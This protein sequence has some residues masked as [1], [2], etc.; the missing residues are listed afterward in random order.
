MVWRASVYAKVTK[1][2]ITV[3]AFAV[4][5]LAV[6]SCLA[7]AVDAASP[8]RLYAAGF[9][10]SYL[11]P[12][13][14]SNVSTGNF[15]GNA[16][17]Y[18]IDPADGRLISSVPMSE[19]GY[20]LAISPS[21]TMLYSA[22]GYSM[23]VTVINLAD[24]S[25]A[26]HVSM[27]SPPCGIVTSSDGTKIYVA[28]PEARTIAVMDAGTCSV[29][30]FIPLNISPYSLVV[31][32]DGTMLYAT[33]SLDGAISAIDL[34]G[35]RLL[36]TVPVG[37]GLSEA[38]FIRNH[39][40]MVAGGDDTVYAIDAAVNAVK[41]AI[42]G[43]IDPSYI[44]FDVSKNALIVTS[45]T[46]KN[47]TKIDAGGYN[48]T[49]TRAFWSTY[50]RRPA[51]S[52]DGSWLYVPDEWGK[53]LVINA[54]SLADT[55]RISVAYPVTA[56]TYM[57]SQVVIPGPTPTP[58]PAAPTLYPA[59]S[60][61]TFYPGYTSSPTPFTTPMPTPPGVSQVPEQSSGLLP[62][63]EWVPPF[64]IRPITQS[65]IL[66]ILLCIAVLLVILSGI[67]YLMMFQKKKE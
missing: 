54:S 56:L 60:G 57:P 17:L 36:S 64:N 35:N 34:P 38:V 61:P 42:R 45:Q 40:V 1:S 25:V 26:A 27:N 59:A 44:V 67:T 53:I 15:L 32:S 21:G 5:L 3:I 50:Y 18:V 30:A 11:P 4:I 39:T 8:D 20:F 2:G 23:N 10:G 52:G 41:A 31:S 49:L 24:M 16:S 48:I 63:R 46:D 13:H 14:S 22:N 7:G 19:A 6:A 37:T 47:I 29:E 62:T 28:L 58:A 33:S 43:V 65:D 12:G 9:N 66:V 55:G 51:V